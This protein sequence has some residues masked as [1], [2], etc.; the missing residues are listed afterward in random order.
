M[1]FPIVS[2]KWMASGL[3][4]GFPSS[5]GFLK[6]IVSA[7]SKCSLTFV[8]VFVSILA[9][10]PYMKVYLTLA[11]AIQ[12]WLMPISAIIAGPISTSV[13]TL[14]WLD[15]S[16]LPLAERC[17]AHPWW[18]RGA[19]TLC[20]TR[21]P[22]DVSSKPMECA[23]SKTLVGGS[24]SKLI[25]LSPCVSLEDIDYSDMALFGAAIPFD[26]DVPVLP[27]IVDSATSAFIRVVPSDIDRRLLTSIDLLMFRLGAG[28]FRSGL[29]R[30]QVCVLIGLHPGFLVTGPTLEFN[31]LSG[32]GTYVRSKD[33]D[34]MAK[35]PFTDAGPID[36][37]SCT[38]GIIVWTYM[39][40]SVFM[41][42]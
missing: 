18:S 12:S 27:G 8:I 35:R 2:S 25:R 17:S 34:T 5:V 14:L 31:G 37:S 36:P 19:S 41:V 29:K 32:L 21:S 9:T 22:S 1:W 3:C 10:F 33:S 42:P 40:E 4:S 6:P 38:L 15:A 30:L 28:I 20:Y 26:R 23:P 16:L 13:I 11:G 39:S 7:S 24:L